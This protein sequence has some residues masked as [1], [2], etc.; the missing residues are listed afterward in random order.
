M[1]IREYGLEKRKTTYKAS[2]ETPSFE[3]FKNV[4]KNVLTKF[5]K[6][7][8]IITIKLNIEVEYVAKEEEKKHFV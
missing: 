7:E 4:I 5:G 3:E 8:N 2:I 1:S 6:I